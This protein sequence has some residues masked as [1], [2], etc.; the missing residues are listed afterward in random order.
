MCVRRCHLRRLLVD[1]SALPDKNNNI[2]IDFVTVLCTRL[3]SDGSRARAI[4]VH[5]YI[6]IDIA[7]DDNTY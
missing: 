2:I 1:F 4:A 7:D 6:G 5:Y 3:L